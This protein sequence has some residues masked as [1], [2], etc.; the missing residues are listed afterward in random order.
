[1]RSSLV[2]G[3]VVSAA[4]VGSILVTPAAAKKKPPP[5]P[6]PPS[7]SSTYVRTYANVVDGVKCDVTPEVVQATSDGGSIV[8][9]LSGASSVLSSDSCR[10]VNWLVKLDA[11][12]NPQWQELVGCFSLPPGDYTL[13]VSLQQTADGGYVL[14]GG[15]LGCG[16]EGTCFSQCGL[17]EKVNAN[18]GLVW[19]RVYKSG[20]GDRESVINKI[21][22]TSDGGFI[23]AGSFRDADDAIGAWIVKLDGAGN[24]QWQRKLG[25]GGPSGVGRMHVYFNAVQRTADGGYFA[26]GEFFSYLRRPE[27]D[28]GALAVKFDANGAVAWQRGFL[29]F[30]S[31]GVPTASV[32]ALSSIQTSDGGYLVAGNWGNGT[33][34]L[35]ACCR[36]ALLLKLDANGSVAWQKAY[37]G[38]VYC[39]F[40]GFNTTCA[41]IGADV[42]SVHE[43]SDGGYSLA[44][45]AN[46][47]E[48]DGAP[49]QPWLAK[50]DAGGNLLWQHLYYLTYPSTG[51]PVSEYFASSSL[52]SDGGILALGFTGTTSSTDLVGEL[53]AVRTDGAGNV[54]ACSEIH[55]AEPLDAL[56]PGLATIAP[57]L[58]VQATTA[59]QGDVPASRTQPNSIGGSSGHC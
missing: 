13:G 40:N 28:T 50:V 35:G 24:V 33:G 46:L 53:L 2:S 54:G 19:A 20:A 37:S 42:Y 27:G 30:D 21:S 51:R 34:P 10:G 47:R 44:G 11:S 8:L 55:P 49:I 25:P 15:T 57:G 58:P 59:V 26:S 48:P 18:G 32:H 29:S 56:D 41:A 52:R 3:L 31:S 39:F 9:A 1:M 36:G 22:Q 16:L 4:V 6:P 7:T 43:T 12:G 45:S 5:P 23:A 38:G 14:G 17:V